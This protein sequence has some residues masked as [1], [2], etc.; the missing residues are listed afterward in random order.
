[1]IHPPPRY[2]VPIQDVDL[3]GDGKLWTLYALEEDLEWVNG[4][5]YVKVGGRIVNAEPQEPRERFTEV[6][7]REGDLSVLRK[8]HAYKK[9]DVT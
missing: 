9:G 6:H 3:F 4:R 7:I 2:V 5:R 1:M 8:K